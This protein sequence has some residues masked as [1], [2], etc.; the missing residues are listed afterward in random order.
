MAVITDYELVKEAFSKDSFMGR[1]PD[2]PF[3]FSEE[4]LRSGA[5]NG[6]PWKHQRRFSLHMFR[7]LGFGKT[8]MEEHV[9]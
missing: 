4:T 8:K 5:M 7:D 1:P 9:K 3:E 2:L 6:M